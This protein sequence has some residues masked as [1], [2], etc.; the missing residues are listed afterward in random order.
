M[1]VIHHGSQY[2][3]T[4]RLERY[5]VDLFM[6]F[7]VPVA[8]CTVSYQVYQQTAKVR[9]ITQAIQAEFCK[10]PLGVDHLMTVLL[11]SITACQ[12]LL[13]PTTLLFNMYILLARAGMFDM[14]HD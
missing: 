2:S 14:I 12:V 13:L 8:I 3:G 6:K 1:H 9:Y 5:I 11:A 7:L 4:S 10:S